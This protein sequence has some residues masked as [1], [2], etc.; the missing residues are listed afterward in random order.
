MKI[1]KD[2]TKLY[3]NVKKLLANILPDSYKIQIVTRFP[4][5]KTW[6]KNQTKDFKKCSTRFELYE[7]LQKE[8]FKEKSIDYLEF[9][10]FEGETI[11]F[12]RKLNEN[13]DSRFYGFDTF[14]GLPENWKN[15]LSDR[16]KGTWDCQGEIPKIDDSRV[17][18]FKGVFQDTLDDFLQNY[19]SSNQ[20]VIHNDSDLY[21]STL[22]V[23]TRTHDII[24]K[25]TIII[26]DEF[27][28]VMDE[29]RALEDYCISYNRK[30]KVIASTD[31]YYQRIAI[32][33]EN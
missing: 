7:F 28:N 13:L 19:E 25:D 9:G 30:Y 33:F 15:L 12:W 4:K 10:V 5:L 27:S 23:L 6:E 1:I 14:T 24:K 26:F 21:S 31:D 16:P 22:Y 3:G 2:P 20:I 32:K 8:Y 17:E 29:F 18:F 11:D